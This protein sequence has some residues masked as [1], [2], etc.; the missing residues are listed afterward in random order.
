MNKV[1]KKDVPELRFPEFVNDGEW[2]E[3]F[4]INKFE[5]QDG[6]SFPSSDFIKKSNNSKQV[7]RIT[8]INNRNQN[9][10]KVFVSEETS[11]KIDIRRYM[12][13][14]GD[15]LLSLTGAA[16][17]NF[18]IWN[19]DDAYI[20]QRTMKIL[21][22]NSRDQALTILLEPLI[23]SKINSIGAGQN[24]NLSRDSLKKIKFVFPGVK[25]QQKIANCISSLDQVIEAQ[26]GKLEV[27][28]IHKKGLMQSFF[29]A[30]GETVPKL[31]FAEFVNE[32][33]WEVDNLAGEKVA[34]FIS[35]KA[36]VNNLDLNT[37]ISTENLLPDYQG[38]TISLK[39]PTS[40]SFNEF[41]KG[42]ILLSNIRPYLKKVWFSD[43]DGAASNDVL[44]IRASTKMEPLFLSFLLKNDAFI[45]YVMKSAEGVKMPRGD[46]DVIKKYKLSFPKKLEQQKI[47]YCLSFLD[48]IIYEQIK[49]IVQLKEH[50]KGLMQ[51]LFPII[52]E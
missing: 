20:N 32:E 13:R 7:I 16:G 37:Y 47:A 8:D 1:E 31:R 39:L 9:L 23:H 42:D 48:E 51:R 5:F 10:D 35:K 6:Y 3:D 34:L 33:G 45:E 28:K 41:K 30:D 25:E 43:R 44:V 38:A 21:P 29:P 17:F 26:I 52:T 15:L 22:K 40:G 14:G 11:K 18:F 2:E 4:I 24:N 19:S 12:V 36:D 46:K 27:L 50:K 49:K